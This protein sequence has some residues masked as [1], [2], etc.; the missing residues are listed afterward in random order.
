M[1]G[2]SHSAFLRGFDRMRSRHQWAWLASSTLMLATNA[3]AAD[4][5]EIRLN[6]I[7]VIGTHN[8]YHA[9][10][11]AGAEQLLKT[12]RPEAALSLEYR[13][14]AL[15]RQLSAGIR[16]VEIDIY[17]DTG[18]GR[19]AHPK[20]I[21]WVASAGLPADAPW[22]S[23]ATMAKPGFKVLHTQDIDYR[24]NCQPL[25]ACLEIIRS[26]SKAHPG[27][28]PVFILIETKIDRPQSDVELTEP[29]PFTSRTFDALDAEI[30]SVFPQE[31]MI[32]PDQVRGK[33]PTLQAAIR[34]KRWPT[35]REARG[36]VIF[37][38][39]QQRVAPAYLEGHPSLRGRILF[40][41]A[42]P[43]DPDAAFVE[44]NENDVEAI[45]G[46][47]RDGYLVRARTDWD[48]RQARANDTSRRDALLASGAQILSTDYPIS[49]PASWTGYRVGFPENRA[50][51]CNPLIAP[52]NC[53]S[54]SL[55]PYRLS[56]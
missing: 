52:R 51:R 41:N 3:P 19:F 54:N 48:T 34:A 7:Q 14:P 22:D 24:S 43:G 28:S 47:V 11:A 38:M 29:E 17:A 8:S 56:Y 5:D 25:I 18:G 27:H 30:R 15:D 13:H 55:D 36:K 39:D 44:Q 21:D 4:P 16:Q 35:L 40:T 32:V 9:G 42:R 37:L 20:A 1:A 12:K 53:R 46:L 10:L 31:A 2:H 6:E 45:N 49:E 26:W 33:F 23:P 50:A